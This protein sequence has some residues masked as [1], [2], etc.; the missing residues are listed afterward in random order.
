[1]KPRKAERIYYVVNSG[2]VS[3]RNFSN[4]FESKTVIRYLQIF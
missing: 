1:M 3:N 2:S 4:I